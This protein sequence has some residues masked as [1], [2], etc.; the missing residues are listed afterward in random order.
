MDPG[1]PQKGSS[2]FEGV[3]KTLGQGDGTLSSES[4]DL[5]SFGKQ[6]ACVK[7]LSEHPFE[8]LAL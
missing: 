8:A 2:L 1:G 3:S 4:P 5:E 7:F 6:M